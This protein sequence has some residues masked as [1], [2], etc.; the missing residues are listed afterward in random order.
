MREFP[1]W[2]DTDPVRPMGFS[3]ITSMRDVYKWAQEFN[4]DAFSGKDLLGETNFLSRKV[5]VW[6]AGF[7]QTTFSRLTLQESCFEQNPDTKWGTNY[8]YLRTGLPL[9]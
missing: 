1:S 8:K 6:N 4:K 9:A 3:K 7:L 2:T 5:G